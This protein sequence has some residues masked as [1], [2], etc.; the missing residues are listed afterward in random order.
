MALFLSTPKIP[1]VSVLHSQDSPE[2]YTPW[3]IVERARVVMGSIDL[4]PASHDE[5][6]PLIKAITYYTEKENG[7]TSPWWG[8]VFVNPPGGLVPQFWQRFI[9]MWLEKQI[10]QGFWVGYSLE[11]FQTLQSQCAK[12]PHPLDYSVCI[13]KQRIPFVEN[14]AK[15][16]ERIKK[17][18]KKGKV[19]NEKSQPSHGNYL[20]YVGENKSVFAQIFS[21]IGIVVLR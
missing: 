1:D 21:E 8:N 16:Q 18:L 19:P 6:A 15:K 3:P 14:K 9:G 13:P 10:T 7:L 2:W 11:Q 5:A 12:Y 17:L 20:V 4:D